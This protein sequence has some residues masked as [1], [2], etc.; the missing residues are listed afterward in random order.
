MAAAS[1]C[2]GPLEQVSKKL[3][4]GGNHVC[5]RKEVLA[6]VTALCAVAIAFGTAFAPSALNQEVTASITGR[7][8][9][10]SGAS[11]PNATVTATD[12]LRS[13]A[14]PTR[15]N[16][17]GFYSLPRLPVGTYNL[18]VEGQGFQTAVENSILL[19]LNQT[20]RIDFQLKIGAVTQMVEVS[21][22]AP[23]LHTDTMQVGYVTNALT[24]IELPLATRNFVQLTLLTPGVV[25]PNP[26]TMMSGQRTG[27]GG[28][29]YVNGNRKE[30][31][32]F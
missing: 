14:W 5:R 25:N 6:R 23:L 28:R 21:G 12:T 22:Q 2:R 11:V 20:A 16:S 17:E 4:R 30:A 19:Q 26:G 8:T 7:V 29:P 1:A 10:P 31:N 13:T 24:N 9:D 18:K 32:N 15:T 3:Q 27:G